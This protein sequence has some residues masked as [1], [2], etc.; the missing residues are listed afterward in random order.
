VILAAIAKLLLYGGVTLV[1]SEITV[2][3]QA[4]SVPSAVFAK[5]VRSTTGAG[6]IALW[7]GVF[8]VLLA[9]ARELELEMSAEGLGMLR[10]TS[11]GDG[12]VFL[13]FS[14]LAGTVAFAMRGGAWIRPIL[15]GCVAVGLGGL[16]HAAADDGWPRASR[17]LDMLH[18]MCVGGWIGG[19]Y[20]LSR[21]DAADTPDGGWANFSITATVLAPLVLLTGI[22]S[23]LLRLRAATFELALGSGYGRLLLLKVAFALVV[24]G[25]GAMHRRRI[26][27]GEVPRA[28]SLRF[29]LAVAALV[30][31]VTS[32]LTGTAPPGE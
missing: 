3:P 2:R 29:E 18:V 15:V 20:L 8:L 6:W 21:V 27:Q 24:L 10:G 13:A 31:V 1:A 5:R 22:L 28:A 14:V 4:G 11:W 25:L 7:S 16:G 9:Q 30:L 23:S 32:V 12:W 17:F 26:R 19:L